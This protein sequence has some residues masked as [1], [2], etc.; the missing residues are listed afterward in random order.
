MPLKDL[1]SAHL[2]LIA[3]ALGLI[4]KILRFLSPQKGW[5]RSRFGKSLW[6][7]LIMLLV[8]I[9]LMDLLIGQTDSVSKCFVATQTDLSKWLHL[10]QAN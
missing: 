10:Q 4:S 5:P 9:P 8:L 6:I 7:L 2:I 1:K 3:I